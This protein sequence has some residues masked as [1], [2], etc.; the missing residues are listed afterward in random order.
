MQGIDFT[1]RNLFNRYCGVNTFFRLLEGEVRDF[2]KRRF[3][4]QLRIEQSGA[5]GC[6]RYRRSRRRRNQRNGS[7]VRG[8]LTS[9]GWISDLQVPRLRRGGYQSQVLDRYRRRQ[10]QVD[11]ALLEA[12]LLGHSTRKAARLFKRVFGETVSAQ[13]VSNIAK[14]LNG[15]VVRFHRRSLDSRY[16]YLY[17]DGIW[18]TL[19]KPVK[20]KK[21]LLVA[22][23]VREDNSKELL[24]FQ[25]APSESEACWWGFLSD[26]KQRGLRGVEVIVSD[27]A[28]GLIKAIRAIYPRASHQLCTFH[29]ARDLGR[30]LTN[31]RH[32]RRIMT[33]ALLV[34][35]ANTQTAVR[36]RLRRF[37]D[38]WSDKEPKAVR[39]FIRNFEYCL[40]YLEYPDPVRTALKTNNPI[41][42]YL[43]ELRRRTIPMRAFNN[44][45]S[46][47]RIIYGIV[48]YV[49]NQQQ[50]VPEY[51]FTQSA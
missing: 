47:E 44:A 46:V 6:G 22:L 7:Y 17:L 43:Q 3:Q 27:G 37:C 19:S 31:K 9:Y 49:L 51:L 15:E 8:L 36:K 41:E 13:T 2:A 12:F 18:M 14:E 1:E 39:A 30:H 11:R 20:V 45:S 26:L 25:L 4:Q 38:K 32:Q 24:G 33:D 35:E 48:A 5:V 34:F 21:V 42:R 29:K 16:R 50:D 28:S 10:R 23:A 40:T